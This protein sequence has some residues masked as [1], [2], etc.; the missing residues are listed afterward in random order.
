MSIAGMVVGGLV[1]LMFVLDLFLGVPF[2]GPSRG[3]LLSDVGLALC[4]GILA[5]LGWNAFRDTK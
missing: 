4:G 5:Y 3:G 1:A 2:G